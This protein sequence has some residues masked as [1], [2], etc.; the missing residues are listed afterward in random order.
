LAALVKGQGQQSESLLIVETDTGRVLLTIAGLGL[1]G[2]IKHPVLSADRNLVLT[3]CGCYVGM[4]EVVTGKPI[5]RFSIEPDGTKQIAHWPAP[6]N[7]KNG[8]LVDHAVSLEALT[9]SPDGRF[10]A[11]SEAQSPSI[12]ARERY[13]NDLK[14]GR[15]VLSVPAPNCG[16]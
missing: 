5:G 16:N 10:I 14:Q 15:T 1:A 6:S 9:L 8:G 4:W 13:A 3:W 7:K 11:T 2:W 12:F